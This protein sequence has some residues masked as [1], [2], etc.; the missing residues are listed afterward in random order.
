[1]S[2]PTNPL[3]PR[4][5][6]LITRTKVGRNTQEFIRTPTGKAIVE[7]AVG[8]YRKAISDLQEMSLQ[9]YEG[10]SSEELNQY[11]K[12]SLNLATPLKLLQWLDAIIADGE[13]AEKLARYQ[14]DE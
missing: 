11:R 5:N 14:D 4:I 6:D 9:E 3:D 2:E 8:D 10:S 7:R 13:N 12:I 1:M